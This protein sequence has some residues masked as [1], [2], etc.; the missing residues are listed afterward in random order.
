MAGKYERGGPAAQPASG[1]GR[2]SGANPFGTTKFTDQNWRILEA[3]RGVAGQLGPPP[4]QVALAWALAQQGITAPIIGASRVAQVQD[5]IAALGLSLSP[6]HLQELA[7]ASA[8]APTFPYAIFT[9]ELNRAAVF[10][11]TSVQGWQ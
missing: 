6:A 8:P 10:G 1:E 11:G 5:N 3:L 9:P 2:L 4:A 7:Q